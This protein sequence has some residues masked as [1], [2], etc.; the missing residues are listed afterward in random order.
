MKPSMFK[1]R[2]ATV[3]SAAL[4]LTIA[5]AGAA[6]ANQHLYVPITPGASG[7][8]AVATYPLVNGRLGQPADFSY[9]GVGTY[10]FAL[11]PDGLFYASDG[12]TTV[13]V[14]ASRANTL[15]YAFQTPQVCF[16][17]GVYDVTGVG[18]DAQDYLYVGYGL[19]GCSGA[20]PKYGRKGVFV[21]A[22][23]QHG[24]TPLF[25]IA[26][27]APATSFTFDNAGDAYISENY[28][29]APIE[30]YSSPH[31]QPKYVRSLRDNQGRCIGPVALDQ[32]NQLYAVINCGGAGGSFVAVYPRTAHGAPAPTRTITTAGG[33][34]CC[35]IA[36]SGR[37][38]YISNGKDMIYQ[39]AKDGRGTLTPISLITTPAQFYGYFALS[40]GP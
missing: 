4:L 19:N 15:L 36:I 14:Y 5:A 7:T 24:G 33:L 17:S 18:I 35:S 13:S 6:S 9:Q 25:M 39:L 8:G 37:S 1:W 20:P 10:A 23:G 12:S 22:P 28:F 21:Y 32:A 38:L 40:V 11:G 31:T 34:G 29:S 16:G 30:V 27:V 2:W 3:L 26:T